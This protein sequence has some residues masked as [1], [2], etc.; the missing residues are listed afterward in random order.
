MKR[1]IWAVL[2]LPAAGMAQDDQDIRY[3]WFGAAHVSAEI[4]APGGDLDAS[5]WNFD[6]S[7]AVR[8]HIHLFGSYQGL[9]LDDFE[10]ADTSEKTFGIGAHFDVID[11]L[12]FFGRLGFIDVTADNGLDTA[13]DDGLRAMAGVRFMPWGGFEFR[14]GVDYIDLDDSGDDTGG[15]IGADIW[16]TDG[17]SLTGDFQFH[18]DNYSILFGGRLYFGE[19]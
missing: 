16:L 6:A 2:F 5:G 19:W 3:S 18:E 10:D 12:S 9:E 13:E 14:G 15:F 4:D 17:I 1:F 11:R 7:F 8:K